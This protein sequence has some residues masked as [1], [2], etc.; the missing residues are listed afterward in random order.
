MLKQLV[1]ELTISSAYNPDR[2]LLGISDLVKQKILRKYS[3]YD[4]EQNVTISPFSTEMSNVNRITTNGTR[5]ANRI[6]ENSL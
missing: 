2:K 4:D 3:D 5:S 1:E 6:S